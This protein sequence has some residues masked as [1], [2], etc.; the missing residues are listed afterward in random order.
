MRPIQTAQLVYFVSRQPNEFS[1]LSGL[2]MPSIYNLKPAFQSFL[3]PATCWLAHFGVTANQVTLTAM[4]LSLTQ[5]VW[6]AWQPKAALP[7]LLMPVTLFVRMALNAIDGLLAREFASGSDLGIILNELGD[8]ISDMALYLP[9]SLVPGVSAPL[10]VVAVCLAS[11][12]EACAIL[13]SQISGVRGNEGPMGKSDRAVLFGALAFAHGL[14]VPGGYGLNCL[15]ILII[16]LLAATILNRING[17]LRRGTRN[18]QKVIPG[19][20]DELPKIVNDLQQ[21]G[22]QQ[23]NRRVEVRGTIAAQIAG[24][25]LQ[26]GKLMLNDP[27]G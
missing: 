14:R 20:K 18:Q 21:S 11:V 12:S 6:V 26:R 13:A 5:G 22:I 7:L 4:V 10:M 9:L 16:V 3:R 17:A 27:E 25:T 19:F 1:A 2:A 8:L 23:V 24:I 15:L